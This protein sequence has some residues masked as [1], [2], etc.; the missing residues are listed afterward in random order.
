MAS[1]TTRR[2]GVALAVASLCIAMAAPAVLA[3][4]PVAGCSNGFELGPM[5]L[6]DSLGLKME[7]GFPPDAVPFYEA[8]FADFDKNGN[9]LLCLKDL[10]DTP[11]IAPW[12]FQLADDVAAAGSS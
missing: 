12:V 1:R 6:E 7:L 3:A 2:I 10:P 5:S 4:K 8:L 9:G 11:G